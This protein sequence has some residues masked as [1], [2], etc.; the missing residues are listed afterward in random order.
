M[1]GAVGAYITPFLVSTG[2]ST[3]VHLFVYLLVVNVGLFEVMRRLGSTFLLFVAIAGTS[4]VLWP[5]TFFG[6]PPAP[7]WMILKKDVTTVREAAMSASPPSTPS[8]GT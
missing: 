4:V 5:A 6:R 1:L 8:S 2:E 3:L 7:S